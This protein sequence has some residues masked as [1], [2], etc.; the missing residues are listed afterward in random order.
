MKIT[1]NQLRDV[2]REELRIDEARKQL[3][4]I[5][6]IAVPAAAT[7]LAA[8]LP[9]IG[10]LGA[11]GGTAAL[12]GAGTAVVVGGT[13]L[14]GLLAGALWWKSKSDSEQSRVMSII[15]QENLVGAMTVYAGLK[16]FGTNEKEINA[17]LKEDGVPKLYADFARV[18]QIMDEDTSEDLQQWLRDDGMDTAATFVQDTIETYLGSLTRSQP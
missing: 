1:R 10:A 9:G 8:A 13:A 6:P 7:G 12:A 17:A 14:A 11:A 2:I 3:N 18:L 16:G 4:E 15:N 5:G